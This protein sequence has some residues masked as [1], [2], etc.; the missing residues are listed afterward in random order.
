MKNSPKVSF[1]V[2]ITLILVLVMDVI[3][4]DICLR[5]AHSSKGWEKHG[6]LKTKTIREQ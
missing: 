3:C 4:Q 1:F 2:K 6:D 5:I